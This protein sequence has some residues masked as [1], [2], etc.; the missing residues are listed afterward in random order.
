MYQTLNQSTK[1][2]QLLYLFIEGMSKRKTRWDTY[3]IKHLSGM[4]CRQTESGSGLYDGGGREAHNHNT[5]VPL[6]HL[7]PKRTARE[8]KKDCQNDTSGGKAAWSS[9][10]VNPC[11]PLLKQARK[12]TI[13]SFQCFLLEAERLFAK[14]FLKFNPK[15]VLLKRFHCIK[16]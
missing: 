15:V 5:N 12:T 9:Q 16:F 7:T 8:N 11:R 13:W 1:N 6:Q 10:Y 3:R 14:A 2:R 4:S